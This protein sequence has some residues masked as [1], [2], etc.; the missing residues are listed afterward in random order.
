MLSWFLQVFFLTSYS[1][2]L[3]Y[4]ALSQAPFSATL[5]LRGIIVIVLSISL[6][7]KTGDSLYPKNTRFQFIRLLNS[8]LALGLG[9]LS[10]VYLSATSIALLARLDLFWILCFEK[11]GRKGRLGRTYFILSLILLVGVALLRFPGDTSLGLMLAVL[12][13]ALL[14]WGFFLAQRSGTEENMSVAILV[15]GLSLVLF[16]IFFIQKNMLITFNWILPTILS[17]ILLFLFYYF[18]LSSFRHFSI[19]TVNVGAL[20]ATLILSA[21][22]IWIFHLPISI[23]LFV[24]LVVLLA[25][26]GVP[27]LIRKH[28]FEGSDPKLSPDS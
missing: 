4:L 15:P 21:V 18:L 20:I 28:S 12:S 10:Y 13:T 19:Y 14:T 11:D 25:I 16:G 26:A 1:I 27:L 9:T 7:W 2:L 3:K 17:G 22:E 6:A 8:G 5:I 23:R 24:G